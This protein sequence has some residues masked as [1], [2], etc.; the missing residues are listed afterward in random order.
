M[1]K[2]LSILA[3]SGALVVGAAGAALING[4]M[5]SRNIAA[6]TTHTITFD[7]TNQYTVASDGGNEASL[8]LSNTIYD[9]RQGTTN[10]YLCYLDNEGLMITIPDTFKKVLSLSIK[11]GIIA[12]NKPNSGYTEAWLTKTTSYEEDASDIKIRDNSNFKSGLVIDF[13]F[14]KQSYVE[15]GWAVQLWSNYDDA[16][17][18]DYVSLTYEC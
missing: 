17:Y 3:L 12:S 18:I 5:V 1:N 10:Y 6:A 4:N 16:V 14:S 2:K 13:D 11:Y 9:S 8:S 15:G 7:K